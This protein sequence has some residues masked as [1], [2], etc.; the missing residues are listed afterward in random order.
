MEVVQTPVARMALGRFI[1]EQYQTEQESIRPQFRRESTLKLQ[2]QVLGWTVH[3][4]GRVDGMIEESGVKV[5]EEVKSTAMDGFRLRG[6]DASDWSSYIHQVE[7]Y[8]WMFQ[9]TGFSAVSGRLILISVLDGTRHTLGVDLGLGTVDVRIRSQ[10]TRLVEAR[11]ARIQWMTRRRS[12]QVVNPYSTWRPGQTEIVQATAESLESGTP[13]MIQAPTGSG[14]T[15]PILVSALAHVFQTNRQVFLV[16]SAND[17]A[18]C[19]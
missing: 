9:E 17:P 6:T 10:L 3:L 5:V 13:L 12:V 15:A 7:T 14:K 18:S 19:R 4:M 2:F 8:L 16:D 1:H 11:E